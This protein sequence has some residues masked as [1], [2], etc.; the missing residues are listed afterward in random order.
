WP[1]APAPPAGPRCPAAHATDRP[2]P[3]TRTGHRRVRRRSSPAA[4]ARLLPLLVTRRR[5][6]RTRRACPRLEPPPGSTRHAVPTGFRPGPRPTRWGT[7]PASPRVR[8][9]RA[10]S[11]LALWADRAR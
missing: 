7:Q 11:A 6:Q 1:P 4:L 5:R 2:P 3:A 8:A 10:T 9:P